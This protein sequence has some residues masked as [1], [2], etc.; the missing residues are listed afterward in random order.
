MSEDRTP[1]YLSLVAATLMV[2]AVLTLQPYSADWPGRR[3]I[4][5]AEVYVRAAMAQ[6]S[7]ALARLSV[8]DSP[9]A[10]AL[11]MSR[12]NPR[13]LAAWA[14][15][16]QA[17]TGERHGDTTQVFVYS[18]SPAC[19]DAPIKF[20]FVDRPSGARVVAAALACPDSGPGR[21]A[22]PRP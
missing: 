16:S 20:R 19:G 12:R 6:D 9:V 7:L 22:P 21:R 1:L 18:G 4:R 5:P 14:H 15:N 8:A 2:L 11:A 3:F 17:Y 10:W 13:S